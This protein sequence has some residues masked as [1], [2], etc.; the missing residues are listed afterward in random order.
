MRLFQEDLRREPFWMLVACILVNRATWEKAAPIFAE[1]QKRFYDGETGLDGQPWV[2]AEMLDPLGFQY[3][4]QAHLMQFARKW[5]KDGPPRDFVHVLR[6]PGCGR[7]AS[8]SWRI[9]VEEKIENVIPTDKKLYAY[10]VERRKYARQER[11]I[12]DGKE[13]V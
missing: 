6:Y 1:L 3:A 8:D 11:R 9:F 13:S 4:R 12:A 10:V 7:Y 2:T 5:A